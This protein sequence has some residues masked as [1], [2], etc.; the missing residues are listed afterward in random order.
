MF[1]NNNN[2]QLITGYGEGRLC[3]GVEKGQGV[4]EEK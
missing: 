4:T 3:E 2:K 1:D